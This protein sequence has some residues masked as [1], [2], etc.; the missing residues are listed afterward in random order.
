MHLAYK[1]EKYVGRFGTF[2]IKVKG[3]KT[4][5]DGAVDKRA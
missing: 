2:N 4:M 1:Y 5:S 3:Q